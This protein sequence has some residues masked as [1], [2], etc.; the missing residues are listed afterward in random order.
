MTN[1]NSTEMMDGVS[2][3]SRSAQIMFPSLYHGL[4]SVELSKKIEI[5]LFPQLIPSH[6]LIHS[7]L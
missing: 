2:T 4:P 7:D 3:S 6:S 5:M 1:V